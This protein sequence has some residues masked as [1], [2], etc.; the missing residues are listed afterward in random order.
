MDFWTIALLFA[1]GILAGGVS[2]VAGGA[3]FITFPLVLATGLSPFAAGITNYIALAPANLIALIGYREELARVRHKLPVPMVVSAV[4]GLIGSLLLIWSGAEI[5]AR[6]VPW[7][8]FAATALF[9][10]GS[11]I[12]AKLRNRA[13]L[14]GPGWESV[15]L[16]CQFLLALYGG[17]FGAGMG[18]VLLAC[19]NIFGYDNLHEANTVK[20][21]FICVFSVIGIVIL[22]TSGQMSWAHGLPIGIGTIVGAYGA[23]RFVRTLPEAAV[24]YSIL[25]WAAF[26]TLY[27]FLEAA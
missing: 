1:G 10:L 18:F 25:A 13:P 23:V 17:Y 8:L 22:L 27:Y 6:L 19:L 14:A 20:N 7:L 21:A 12:K 16:F 4:G 11:W 9:A 15:S 5:F 2:A 26:L 24:R 3:S